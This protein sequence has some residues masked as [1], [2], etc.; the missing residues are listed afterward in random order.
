MKLNTGI[1]A[2]SLPMKPLG[3]C[4]Q[5]DHSL[6]LSDIRALPP[7]SSLYSEDILYFGEWEAVKKLSGKMPVYAVCVGGGKSALDFFKLHGITGIVLEDCG[8]PWRSA[9]SKAFSCISTS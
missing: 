1:I 5:T 7:E 8:A 3:L 9:S 4:G 6:A 2:N